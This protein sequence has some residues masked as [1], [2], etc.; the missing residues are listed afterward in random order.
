MGANVANE[1]AMGKMCESTLA[2]NFG[3]DRI[4]E[5]IRQVFDEPP[6][7]RVARI[8]DVAGAEAC[9]ALK[10]IV[11]LGAGFVD[12]LGLGGNTKA[13][14]IRV[15]LLDM[16]NFCGMFF[17]GVEQGTFLESCGMADLI[18]T[19]YGGR[20]R[21]CAEEFAKLRLADDSNV[22]DQESC[23]A[24]WTKIETELLHGQKLQGTLAMQEVHSILESRKLEESFKLFSMI[25]NISFK[26]E[27]VSSITDAI[28]VTKSFTEMLRRSSS[29]RLEIS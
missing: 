14:L 19:C 20:N 2:G 21:K 26:G 15:G 1:V 18:T 6:N 16:A 24:M 13:A 22:I 23:N 9:G 7:F 27:P 29:R 17:A 4:N 5:R 12:A 11:A 10:N 28:Q 3:D 25:Y 8:G